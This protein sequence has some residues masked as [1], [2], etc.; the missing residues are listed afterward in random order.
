MVNNAKTLHNLKKF[1][2]ESIYEKNQ[3]PWQHCA[4]SQIE[5]KPGSGKKMDMNKFLIMWDFS[6]VIICCSFMILTMLDILVFWQ[7]IRIFL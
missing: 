1:N 3:I 7:D 6:P 4:Q 2:I 5:N